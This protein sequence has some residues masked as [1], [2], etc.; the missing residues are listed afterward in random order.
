MFCQAKV[1]RLPGVMKLCKKN[2]LAK[3]H[4][5]FIEQYKEEDE[6]VPE[7][8]SLP[9]EREMAISKMAQTSPQ[10]GIDF[11][12]VFSR[13][14]RNLWI[15]KPCVKSGGRG[16]HLIDSIFDIPKPEGIKNVDQDV[17]QKYIS[18]PLTIRG[19]KFDMRLYVLI[20]R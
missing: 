19:H 10:N 18:N 6:F 9:S 7:T 12:E 11:R 1:N 17:L 13:N 20:T 2:E 5:K 3:L 14:D 16:I 15:V 8:F 4:A